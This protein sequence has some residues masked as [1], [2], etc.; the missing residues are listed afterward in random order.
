MTDNQDDFEAMMEADHGPLRYFDMYHHL[1]IGRE[2]LGQLYTWRREKAA[3]LHEP[4]NLGKYTNGVWADVANTLPFADVAVS[5]AVAATVAPLFEMLLC[6]AA[7]KIRAAWKQALPREHNGRWRLGDDDFW[8]PHR[9][10]R[11]KKSGLLAILLPWKR[12]VKGRHDLRRGYRQL[13]Q[14]LGH[15]STIDRRAGDFLDAILDYR[16]N[17]L[18]MG[19]EWSENKL[20][21]FMKNV[22]SRKWD[23]WFHV[24]NRNSAPWLITMTDQLVN[25]AFESLN[26]TARA[27]RSVH[28]AI[29]ERRFT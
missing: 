17:A 18:H 22:K 13:L 24:V 10:Y 9:F 6:R 1:P 26:H 20:D 11:R 5:H 4:P 14:A 29:V 8:D 3:F 21:Q 19:Y 16:N 15:E 23:A 25:K 28:E 27:L 7:E 12:R 2:M